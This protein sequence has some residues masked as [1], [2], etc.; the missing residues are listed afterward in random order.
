M[1]RQS[2]DN[3]ITALYCR[4]SQDDGREGESNSIT[5]QKA[6]LEKF[7]KNNGMKNL[8]FFI[9]DGWSGTNFERP[10]FTELKEEIENGNIETLI[11]K[12]LSRL[13]R[14]HI[15]VG[16]YTEMYFPEMDVRFIAINDNVDTADAE[17]NEFAP[18]T[19]IFNV[20]FIIS[21]VEVLRKKL[22]KRYLTKLDK[23][24]ITGISLI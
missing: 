22:C 6:I 5:N 14:D 18:F 12:D 10:G 9:D 4:L 8:R 3:K 17:S 23:A 1:K 19:N 20:I 13:G 16:Y 7:A 24:K 21:M 2:N 11:V 15:M